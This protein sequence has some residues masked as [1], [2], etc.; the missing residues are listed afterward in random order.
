MPSCHTCASERSKAAL[1]VTATYC[2]QDFALKQKNG[3]V[4]QR[5]KEEIRISEPEGVT[6]GE[7]IS[8]VDR[9]FDSPL[10]TVLCLNLTA[11]LGIFKVY[12]TTYYNRKNSVENENG[13]KHM[14]DQEDLKVKEKLIEIVVRIGYVPSSRTFYTYLARDYDMHIS[15][16][17]CR[18]LM[19]EM[20]LEPISGRPPSHK[21][22]H[23][24]AKEKGTHC[25]PCA[26]VE[27]L[28]F[29]DFYRGPRKIILTDITNL[30]MLSSSYDHSPKIDYRF[31]IMSIQDSLS[32]PTQSRPPNRR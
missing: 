25:H 16:L 24:A 20:N 15:I 4:L 13:R 8:S 5:G 3:V 17:R 29:Q 9:F 6:A 18:R 32:S 19:D 14:L 30:Y 1:R 21:A 7:K 31:T 23:K 12:R 2:P 26:A 28:V 10:A 22:S 11:V 27:N